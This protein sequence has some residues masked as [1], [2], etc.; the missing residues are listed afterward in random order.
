[1]IEVGLLIVGG[2][3]QGLLTLHRCVEA[4]WRD[5]AL[6]TRDALGEG[7][8]LH[9]HGYDLAGY[10]VPPPAAAHIEDFKASSAFWNAWTEA[11]GIAS[12][13]DHPTYFGGTDEVV[14]ARLKLWAERGL[15]FDELTAA[16]AV[17]EGG[18]YGEE[19]HRVVGTRN[20]RLMPWKIV[21]SLAGPLQQHIIRG[22][23]TG[24]TLADGNVDTCTVTIGGA[25]TTFKPRAVVV[26][27]GR[28]SQALLKRATDAAGGEPLR[29]RL[30]GLHRV[31]EIPMILLRGELP[32]FSGH[33]TDLPVSVMAH[34]DGERPMWIATALDGH[35]TTGEDVDSRVEPPVRDQLVR[36]TIERIHRLCPQVR[37]DAVKYEYSVYT[38]TKIDHPEDSP[39]YYLDDLGVA[40]LRLV[41][42]VYWTTSALAS[43]AVVD[44]FPGGFP[45]DGP[46]GFKAAARGLAAGVPVG[47]ERRVSA[48]QQWSG[49]DA[50]QARYQL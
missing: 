42:P 29:E 13:A 17:F 23:V 26:A 24:I 16:P 49:W 40:N 6:V 35:P 37:D 14:A 27:A 1:M 5:V 41:W 25:E 34:T 21:E 45:A 10:L 8:T 22:E 12:P 20:R 3:I 28:D 39:T 15:V 38:G 47:A 36:N 7:E 43:R 4:G 50:F 32:E 18:V 31:R 30:T 2:G 19:G 48:I 9:S 44:S 46:G 11:H 33:F